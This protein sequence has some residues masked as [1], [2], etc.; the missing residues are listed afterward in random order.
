MLT[1][2]HRHPRLLSLVMRS[3]R[4][5]LLGGSNSRCRRG[6]DRRRRPCRL[7]ELETRRLLAVDIVQPLAD[8]SVSSGAEATIIN[9]AAA[10]DLAE[11]TGTVVRLSSNLGPDIYAELFDAPGANRTRTTPETVANFLAYV[12]AGLYTNTFFHRSVPGF[13]VQGGGFRTTVP[14][15]E[16]IVE[17]V[18]QFDPVINEPG[19]TNARGT[20]AMAK[21]GGDP[22]SATNQ[23]FVNLADNAGNLDIQNGGFTAFGRVLGAGM[24]VVDAIANLPRFN[25]GSPFDELPTVGL[26]D[27]NAISRENF[28]TVIGVSRAGELVFTA[29]SS[30]PAL[31]AATIGAD[32]S[33]LLDYAADRGGAAT[34]T[35]RAASVFDPS[36]FREQQFTVTLEGP[37]HWNI[38]ENAGNVPLA[39]DSA[40]RLFAGSTM[41]TLGES[42]VDYPRTSRASTPSSGGTRAVPSTSGG[43]RLSGH[44]RPPRAG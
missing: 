28:V 9:L 13:V 35:V 26:D 22:N 40:G 20:L 30:D 18:P 31:A 14:E 16:N 27:P 43:S 33:L 2:W 42:P 32:G 24:D 34:I 12:D 7:E 8:I 21:L 5:G 3:F 6:L 17:T 25:Y 44:N 4:L 39:H 41:I 1:S 36:D 23:F 19:N 38:L 15:A 37:D 29:T 10:F 11:V